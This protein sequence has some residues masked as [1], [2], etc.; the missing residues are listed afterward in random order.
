MFKGQSSK[1]KVTSKREMGNVGLLL[2]FILQCCHVSVLYPTCEIIS[3]HRL[4][5]YHFPYC[6][7]F[8]GPNCP[9]SSRTETQYSL[10]VRHPPAKQN[11]WVG[12]LFLHSCIYNSSQISQLCFQ[13]FPLINCAHPALVETG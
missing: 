11:F 7:Q 2:L 4:S 5:W 9:Q 13:S 1:A 8:P 3:K 6:L 12:C 10:V